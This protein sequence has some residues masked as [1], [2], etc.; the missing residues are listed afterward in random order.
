M[1]FSYILRKRRPSHSL[2]AHLCAWISV[3]VFSFCFESRVA[4]HSNKCINNQ[5]LFLLRFGLLDVST[6]RLFD[7]RMCMMLTE[8]TKN[9]INKER[10]NKRSEKIEKIFYF[11]TFIEV[12]W[13]VRYYC[14]WKG[15]THNLKTDIFVFVVPFFL[16][17][18][19][20]SMIFFSSF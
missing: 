1:H 11:V 16:L 12:A 10:R 9:E 20:R 14:D 2:Y 15:Q 13:G 3:V 19:H 5:F 8:Q 7:C 4:R 17:L 18:L 6:Q